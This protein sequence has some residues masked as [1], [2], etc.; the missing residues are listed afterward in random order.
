MKYRYLIVSIVMAVASAGQVA[1]QEDSDA[2]TTFDGLV[3]IKKGVF[4]RSWVDPDV[5]LTQYTKIL[6]GGAHFEFRAVK[7]GSSTSISRMNQREF[8]ISDSNQQKLID[9]VS[10]IFAE[11]VAKSK[12]FTIVD[13]AGPDVLVL[14]GGLLD[15][16]SR[17]PPDLIGRGEIY[18][19]SVGEATLVLELLD[20]LSGETIY[21]GVER[22]VARSSSIDN[23]MPSNTVTTWAEVRRWARR[24]A[25]RLRD[26]LDSIHK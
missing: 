18:L 2:G 22:K 25:T 6:P 8:Y 3:E 7:K 11:E 16:V 4:K 23:M 15:I 12:H 13:E 10:Q 24:W 17:V 19:S 14:R 20:S 1:G 9:T 5:D 26:G 21:P